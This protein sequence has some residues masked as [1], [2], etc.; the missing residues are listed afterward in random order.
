MRPHINKKNNRL[1]LGKVVKS[2]YKPCLAIVGVQ[3]AVGTYILY[4][5]NERLINSFKYSIPFVNDNCISKDGVRQCLKDFKV[6]I[7]LYIKEFVSAVIKSDSLE[8]VDLDM[9]FKEAVKLECQRQLKDNCSKDGWA[10]GI[11]N[12]N[13][14]SYPVRLRS[15]G[16]R[17][18]HR[19]S[20]NTMSF[21]ADIRGK[22][23]YRGMEEF[24]I[25]MPIIRNYTRELVATKLMEDE[26]IVTPRQFYIRLFINGEYVGLRHVEEN[27]AREL[28]E[29]SK[30]RYGP[31]FSLDEQSTDNLE[32]NKFDLADKKVWETSN[33]KIVMEA[34]SILEAFR[35]DPIIFNKYFDLKLWAK[36]MASMDILQTYHGSIPKSVKFY[37]N[38]TT[39]LIEPVFY[40]GH[41]MNSSKEEDRIIDLRLVDI[42]D[43]KI[44]L[45]NCG[46]ICGPNYKEV[47]WYRRIFGTS[48]NINSPFYMNYLESLEKYTSNEYINNKLM[49]IWQG[50]SLERGMLYKEFWRV[51]RKLDKGKIIHI[52]TWSEFHYHLKRIRSEVE[53]ARQVQPLFSINN[54]GTKITLLNQFSRLP[55]IVQIKCDANISKPFVLVKNIKRQFNLTSLGECNVN[56]SYFSLDKFKSEYLI[57]NSYATSNELNQ[58]IDSTQ[59][60]III[61]SNKKLF[62]T[63]YSYINS[64]KA[65]KAQNITFKAGSNICIRKGA[66]LILSSP[67]LNFLG[68][69]DN[70]VK[71]S[72]CGKTGGSVIIENSKVGIKHLII[73]NLSS[74]KEPLRLLYGGLN[75][76]K[77]DVVFNNL[78][79]EDSKSEDGINF[80]DSQIQGNKLLANKIFSDAIDSDYSTLKLNSVKCKNVGNDCVDLSGSFSQVNT[81]D[82]ININDK[83]LSVGESSSIDV[84]KIKAVDSE[85]G[86][87]SKDSS[88]LNVESY[89]FSSIKLPLAAFIK[90]PEMGPPTVNILRTNAPLTKT[91]LIAKDANVFISGKRVNSDLSSK[92]ISDKLYGNLFGVKTSR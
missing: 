41:Q 65:I 14:I 81:I 1:F 47:A 23:R 16:D 70:P 54:E 57:N 40:D 69:E 52:D 78:T 34:L 43:P 42:I 84:K 73:N 39:G 58:V 12:A 68:N 87:V 72:G 59:N 5:N 33:R 62:N 18:I 21:K 46:W 86:I 71:I 88:N 74:P 60:N 91:S 29:S 26:G 45:K 77:S 90:K 48:D 36:Y 13:G 61:K 76:I 17:E 51:D 24:A 4:D 64:S 27:F 50:L 35:N 7:Q 19:L 75:I 9:K 67:S 30:R 28:V 11:L 10:R 20:F 2:L 8:R 83:V 25:Q 92:E 6:D 55:Q 53:E 3:L 38:P 80:I 66:T 37:L 49:P 22:K 32:D 82:A 56:N 63:G 15:K 31:V 89:V 79:I 44:D 85:I